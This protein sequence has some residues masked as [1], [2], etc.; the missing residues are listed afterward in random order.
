MSWW[1]VATTTSSAPLAMARSTTHTTRGLPAMSAS[2]LP[3]SRVE[4]MRAGITTLKARRSTGRS[5][6]FFGTKRPGFLLEHHRDVVLHGIGEAIALADELG[7][8]PAP[9]Q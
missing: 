1:S 7:R 6:L 4:R 9:Q 5:G 2:I 8:I 3:A